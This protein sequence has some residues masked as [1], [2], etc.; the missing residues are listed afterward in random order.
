YEVVG[1]DVGAAAAIKLARSV[2]VKGLEAIT[3][4]ALMAAD[5]AGCLDRVARSLA[6][7][8]P[9]LGWPDFAAYQLERSLT[10]GT[11]RSEEMQESG[12]MLDELGLE[13]DLAR[14]IAA[15]HARM[16]GAGASLDDARFAVIMRAVEA[17]CA[18]EH[19]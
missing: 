7:S 9:G 19:A 4:E 16:G 5:A 3:V 18:K 1:P 12:R 13:G 11:R 2:F 10:H 6:A 14:A 17:A 15:V 8:F